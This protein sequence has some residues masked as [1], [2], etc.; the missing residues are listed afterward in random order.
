MNF[1]WNEVYPNIPSLGIDIHQGRI[2]FGNSLIE[3][4]ELKN[5][6]LQV[7]DLY[8]FE[9]NLQIMQIYS[10]FYSVYYLIIYPSS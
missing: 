6:E 8:K 1:Y 5:I 4:Y 10:V 9:F 2:D 3:K 7:G